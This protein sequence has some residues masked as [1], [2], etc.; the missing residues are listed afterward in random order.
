MTETEKYEHTNKLVEDIAKLLKIYLIKMEVDIMPEISIKPVINWENKLTIQEVISC[1]DSIT[2]LKMYPEGIKTKK[3]HR[4]LVI[5]RQVV[6][7]IC[8]KM[9]YTFTEIAANLKIDHATVIHGERIVQQLLQVE[10]L[11]MKQIYNDIIMAVAT[12]Y[13]TRYGKNLSFTGQ[14]GNNS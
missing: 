10:D 6:S 11:E 8:R 2:D 9:G 1:A 14:P 3:R 7:Y 13:K 4:G 5:R 12:L